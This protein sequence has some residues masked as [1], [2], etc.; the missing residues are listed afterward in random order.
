[1]LFKNQNNYTI[2][3]LLHPM[4]IISSQFFQ[5]TEQRKFRFLSNTKPHYG[6]NFCNKSELPQ[7]STSLISQTATSSTPFPT[8]F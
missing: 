3:P 5:K 7:K 1:M 4:I 6:Q 8:E 2:D